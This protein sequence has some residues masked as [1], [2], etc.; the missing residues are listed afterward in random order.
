ME[1]CIIYI[2]DNSDTI[3]HFRTISNDT[4]KFF[5]DYHKVECELAAKSGGG[6]IL[7]LFQK[8]SVEADISKIS[9][10]KNKVPSSYIVLVTDQLPKE[11][12]RDYKR[13]G[14]SD[15]S[16]TKL[17]QERLLNAI[18]FIERNQDLIL[19]SYTDNRELSF[20]SPPIWKRTFDIL[21]SIVALIVLSPLLLLT[22]ISIVIESP[23]API[24]KSKRV[25]SNYKMFDFYKFRSMYRDADSKIEQ[26]KSLN[27]YSSEE[28][29]GGQI[30]DEKEFSDATFLDSTLYVADDKL[31]NEEE[32]LRQR[33]IKE[34]ENFIKY[35][36]DPRVTKVGRI[37]RK[38]S[39]DE[40]P[41]LFNIL[42]GDMSVVGNRPLPPY[43]AEQLTSDEYIDRFLAPCG[44]T[45]LWQVEKRGDEG[46]LSPEERKQLDLYYA[47]KYSF[48]M[49]IKIIFK[50]FTAFIQ[51]ENV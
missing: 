37:F 2:G 5:T 30:I 36:N 49:D 11:E 22:V 27:Q 50:T 26:F 45:G 1:T 7:I 44:L 15:T 41:Q 24:Y 19:S 34:S 40:L 51:K 42:I 23:G 10:L 14:I 12:I 39:I 6:A 38:F 31:F 20:Y 48:W 9:Y 3:S 17:T 35:Q 13:A 4:I 33:K 25:G 32:Y 28:C 18:E 29:E 8:E 16:S 47:R 21:F 46:K 43:E